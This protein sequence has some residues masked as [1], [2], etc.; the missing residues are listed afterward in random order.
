MITLLR[1][2]S[3]GEPSCT[4]LTKALSVL[5]HD[6]TKVDD[7]EAS[8]ADT[9]LL[10]RWGHTGRFPLKP[11]A[12]QVN[13][14]RAITLGADKARSRR[15]LQEAGVSVPRS[16][17]D[18]A[19][20]L[21]TRNVRYPLIGRPAS[22][23]QGRDVEV[24]KTAR[25]LADSRSAY[26]S[27]FIDK[28]REFRV[29]VFDGKALGV[30]EKTPENPKDIAWNSHRGAVFTDLNPGQYPQAVVDQA[31]RAARTVGQ[32]FSGVDIMTRGADAYVLELNSS[33]ALSNPHR[34]DL[35]ARAFSQL[36]EAR[37]GVHA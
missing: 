18:I 37:V 29:Y 25:Q 14:P 1:H 15:V 27:E 20:V 12:T 17:F 26:W 28:D 3:I 9:D 24:I 35:F 10:I 32:F 2:R 19:D 23:T 30:V 8:V 22:H 13:E 7:Y 36:I 16:W 21:S 33:L 4:R 11:G 5:G 6:I 31:I 34:V